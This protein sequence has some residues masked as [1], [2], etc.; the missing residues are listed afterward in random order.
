LHESAPPLP[1]NPPPQVIHP[2]QAHAPVLAPQVAKASISS[3]PAK[4]K[5][6]IVARFPIETA[7]VSPQALENYLDFFR[8]AFSSSNLPAYKIEIEKGE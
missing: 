8:K 2:P 4:Q 7:D 1:P 6:V 5:L 3:P